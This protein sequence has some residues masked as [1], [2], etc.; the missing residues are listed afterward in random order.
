[1]QTGDFFMRS[2]IKLQRGE[3]MK[4]RKEPKQQSVLAANLG[5]LHMEI[6]SNREVT[7]EGN[8]GVLEYNESSIKLLAGQYVVAFYGRGLHIICISETD[9]VI[10]GFITSIEYI[11]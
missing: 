2:H 10:R 5:A 11:M 6:S 7:L 3:H 1:M 9:V 8:K 4:R